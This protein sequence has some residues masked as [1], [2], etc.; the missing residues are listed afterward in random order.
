MFIA[1]SIDVIRTLKIFKTTK[2]IF[3]LKYKH[4]F[5]IMCVIKILLCL[6]LSQRNSPSEGSH[7]LS[8]MSACT[9]FVD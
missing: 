5:K 4:N 7:T 1:T 6:A 9:V 8:Q 2:A 3:R